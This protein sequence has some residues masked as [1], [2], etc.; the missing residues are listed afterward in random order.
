MISDP[1]NK[2]KFHRL[3]VHMPG[4]SNSILLLIDIT[5]LNWDW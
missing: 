4:F 1:S 2:L 5:V 3:S